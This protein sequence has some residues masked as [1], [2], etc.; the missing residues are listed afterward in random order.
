[1][2]FFPLDEE[3][4]LLA[5]KYTPHLQECLAL[6]GTLL[7]F[8]KA[9][10]VLEKL[11][12][13]SISKSTAVRVT[14]AAGAAYVALQTEAVAELERTAA[15]APPGV[16]QM[17]VS[18]DG[19]MVS[20]LAGQWGEVRTVAI[21][22]AVCV[23]PVPGSVPGSVPGKKWR[24]KK[25]KHRNRPDLPEQTA[26]NWPD[27]RTHHVTY[28]SRLVSAEAFT[29]LA[30]VET[31]RRGLENSQQAAAIADGAD[32]LQGFADHHCPQAVRILDFPHAAQ[33]IGEIGQSL[34]GA[35]SANGTSSASSTSGTDGSQPAREWCE[36][37]IHSLKHE[38][39]QPLL[40]E[41]QRLRKLHP[42]QE[43]LRDNFAYLHKRRAQMQYPTFAQQGWPIASGMVESA[44]KVVV[45]ARLK[46]AGMH[47]Q[48]SHVD[49]MLA[50]RN[51]YYNQRWEQDW[52]SVEAHLIAQAQQKRTLSCR[53]RLH[54]IRQAEQEKLLAQRRAQYL[55][56][57]PEWLADEG[58]AD[59]GTADE[60]TV[61][62][63][64][65][66]LSSDTHKSTRPAPNHPWRSFTFGRARFHQ[67][68]KI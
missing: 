6:L 62:V 8:D 11:Q 63:A 44:N 20:L 46:G 12:R 42:D 14:E 25:V 29:R 4:G 41:L 38:G 17:V 22:E 30:L 54:D 27:V 10:Q 33:R 52:P 47:W 35:S 64:N 2:A 36:H 13:V 49:A 21:G 5:G 37:W 43:T 59:E 57:H 51:L 39:P 24:K 9:A 32:W 55:A 19:A 67:N 34:F 1:M 61:E 56:L 48:P 7:P 45:Q 28:F 58:T 40:D 60:G 66:P 53:K 23:A 15:A 31:H 50:L 65:A 68:P 18:A 16:R 3:L 26:Q